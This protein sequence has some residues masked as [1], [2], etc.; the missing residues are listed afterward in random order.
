MMKKNLVQLIMV[1][2]LL[3]PLTQGF[4]DW[5]RYED[6]FE[7]NNI[8]VRTLV[9]SQDLENLRLIVGGEPTTV[10]LGSC[11]TLG[12]YEYCYK[13]YSYDHQKIDVDGHGRLVPAV[14]VRVKK[15][16]DP[17]STEPDL[18]ISTSY[19][20]EVNLFEKEK[21][22]IV[23][24]ND[25]NGWVDGLDIRVEV[26]S[27]LKAETSDFSKGVNTISVGGLYIP[28]ESERILSFHYTPVRY[29]DIRLPYTYTFEEEKS[30][31]IDIEVKKPYQVKLDLSPSNTRPNQ[32]ST[33]VVTVRN[34]FY[35]NI[36]LEDF[37][38]RASTGLRV[39]DHNLVPVHSRHYTVEDFLRPGEERDFYMVVEPENIG[40]YNVRNSFSVVINGYEF[41][42]FFMKELDVSASGVTFETSV[43]KKDVKP[44]SNV[45]LV[46]EVTNHNEHEDFYNL[47]YEV[48]PFGLGGDINWLRPGTSFVEYINLSLSESVVIKP[49]LEY[50]FF[51]RK[52]VIE[53]VHNITVIPNYLS[54]SIEFNQSSVR[55][56]EEVS[57]KVF[58]ENLVDNNL[59][60]YYAEDLFFVDKVNGSNQRFFDLKPKEVKELYSYVLKVPE[61]FNQTLH[62][63]TR[64]NDHHLF[65]ASLEVEGVLFES[66]TQEDKEELEE[67]QELQREEAPKQPSW[68]ERF[69]QFI[70]SLI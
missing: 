38:F 44:G 64:I 9:Q 40:T 43:D 39:V 45:T 17:F 10:K 62:V 19:N 48:M 56:G 18:K 60:S 46:V 12:M 25:G 55:R 5:L 36:V 58:V 54:H 28:P 11:R 4:N 24:K 51:S 16:P 67:V 63:Y 65:N 70:T 15:V 68:I 8:E 29:E 37:S 42:E 32:E 66:V 57:V 21:V 47:E 22:E 20:K 1:I 3:V 59:T 49:V 6:E 35:E 33:A 14:R 52:E 41:N 61:D 69:F 23:I 53:N 30:G 34:D 31:N 27:Y 50:W 7:H 13:N 26:P 2:L